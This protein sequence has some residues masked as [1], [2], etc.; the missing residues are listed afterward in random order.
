MGERRRKRERRGTGEVEGMQSGKEH[1]GME[2]AR[3]KRK[4]G[5]TGEERKGRE[6]GREREGRG[7]EGET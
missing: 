4:R 6:G 7:E 3:E 1:N 2:G 5:Q